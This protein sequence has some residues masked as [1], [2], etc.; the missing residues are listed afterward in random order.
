MKIKRIRRTR[1]EWDLNPW[2]LKSPAE[3]AIRFFRPLRHPSFLF[4]N[5]NSSKFCIRR[6]IPNDYRN[7]NL[8]KGS[9]ALARAAPPAGSR[10]YSLASP[11]GPTLWVPQKAAFRSVYTINAVVNFPRINSIDF[12]ESSFAGTKISAKEGSQF[13]SS[14]VIVLSVL[15]SPCPVA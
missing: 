7:V 3:L 1:K 2:E 12:V 8:D 10:Q 6:I 5:D 15:A 13:V 9:K 14:K 11:S 4:K